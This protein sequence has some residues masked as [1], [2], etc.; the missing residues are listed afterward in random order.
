MDW[1]PFKEYQIDTL[2]G[3]K[4]GLHFVVFTI[5]HLSVKCNKSGLKASKCTRVTI[6][7]RYKSN[8]W[9]N[10]TTNGRHW[11]WRSTYSC[12]KSFLCLRNISPQMYNGWLRVLSRVYYKTCLI[13]S[14][15]IQFCI[16]TQA[17]VMSTIMNK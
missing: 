3:M 7:S 15:N 10:E 4:G 9:I 6:V 5:V 8:A 14:S 12:V 13:V 16:K 11:Q 2:Y 1:K 17:Y